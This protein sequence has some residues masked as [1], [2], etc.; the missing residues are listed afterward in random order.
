MQGCHLHGHVSMMQLRGFSAAYR[1]GMGR[2]IVLMSCPLD[3]RSSS[4][5]GVTET[6]QC[7]G[8]HTMAVGPSPR[9]F[10]DSLVLHELHNSGRCQKSPMLQG[11][12]GS[13]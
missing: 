10:L 5:T 2:T 3:A 7:A 9:M 12:Q 8:R 4:G 6:L 11:Q 13:T 1:S